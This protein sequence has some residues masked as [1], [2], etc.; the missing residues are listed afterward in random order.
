MNAEGVEVSPT[1]AKVFS[2]YLAP[3][4]DGQHNFV[5]SRLAPRIVTLDGEPR[6]VGGH[7]HSMRPAPSADFIRGRFGG[8]LYQV[9][10]IKVRKGGPGRVVAN[11][12]VEVYGAVKLE[13]EPLPQTPDPRDE[14]A[15]Q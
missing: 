14:G 5:I 4:D 13:S 15:R 11:H 7:V 8:G 12:C 9:R 1:P 3:Y 10:V 2:D 6:F